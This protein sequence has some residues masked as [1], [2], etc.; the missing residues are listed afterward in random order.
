[1]TRARA[2]RGAAALGALLVVAGC[3]GKPPEIARVFARV[4]YTYDTATQ[5]TSESLGVFL[6]ATDPD[7][8]ENLSAFYVIDDDA[9]LYWKVDKTAWITTSAEGETWVGTTSLA[10]P[11]SSPFPAGTYRI[12]LQD[13]GGETVEQT[14]T[15]PERSVRASK[16]TFPTS[17]V[18]AGAISAGRVSGAYDVWVYGKDGKFLASWGVAG[19]THSLP[20]QTV[21]AALPALADGF[22]WR[23]FAWDEKAGYGV[24]AGPYATGALSRR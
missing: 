1:M 2:A 22:T 9:E 15:I 6:V 10:M 21:T 3:A 14:V 23:V 12:V 24:V 20:L 5:T 8:L 4:L 16:A 17:G 7:G 11:D 19:P 18:H 13:V